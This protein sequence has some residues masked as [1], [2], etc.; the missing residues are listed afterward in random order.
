ME[1]ILIWMAYWLSEMFVEQISGE[2]FTMTSDIKLHD[3]TKIWYIPV[4]IESRFSNDGI[5]SL[6]KNIFNYSI[7]NIYLIHKKSS[8]VLQLLKV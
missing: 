6:I 1:K 7:Y 2:I 4:A 5:A 3:F 8:V